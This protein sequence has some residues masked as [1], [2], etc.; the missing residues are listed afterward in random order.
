V[1]SDD[2]EE[3]EGLGTAMIVVIILCSVA[4]LAIAVGGGIYFYLQAKK[5]RSMLNS[6]HRKTK[7][8]IIPVD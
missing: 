1:T 7:V 2:V 6:P 8:K 5:R 4:L 3:D